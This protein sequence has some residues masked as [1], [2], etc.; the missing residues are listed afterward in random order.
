MSLGKWK[1]K[2]DAYDQSYGID[3]EMRM[4]EY[5]DED[6]YY[7]EWVLWGITY[8]DLMRWWDLEEI[9][10]L[11]EVY[12]ERAIRSGG[13]RKS[14]SGRFVDAESAYDVQRRRELKINRVLGSGRIP[15][16]GTFAIGDMIDWKK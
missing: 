10:T 12:D 7:D 14:K 4:H 16:I 13:L 9:A 11:G 5:V 6:F 1:S 2:S 3:W 15:L 8:E